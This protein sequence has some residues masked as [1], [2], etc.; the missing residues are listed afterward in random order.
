M[1]PGDRSIAARDAPSA[2]K[3]TLSTDDTGHTT[4][5]VLG[6]ARPEEADIERTYSRVDG[7]RRGRGGQPDSGGV[8]AAQDGDTLLI[9][10]RGSRA[11]RG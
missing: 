6:T 1:S 11:S 3:A 2:P 4:G 8:F 5:Q 7:G 9:D 10:V